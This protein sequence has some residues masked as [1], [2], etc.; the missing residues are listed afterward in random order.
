MGSK[1]AINCK[2]FNAHNDSSSN[3]RKKHKNKKLIKSKRTS[4]EETKEWTTILNKD[5][6]A[7]MDE[8]LK[9]YSQFVLLLIYPDFM[10]DDSVDFEAEE[11][12]VSDNQQFRTFG[13]VMQGK[14]GNA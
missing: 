6:S 14:Q 11:D 1:D 9:D 4:A 10:M 5:C 8:I 13:H 12:G 3:Q 2:V 7:K